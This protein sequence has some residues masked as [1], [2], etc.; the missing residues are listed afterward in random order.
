MIRA[1]RKRAKG[2]WN[3][4]KEA[5]NREERRYEGREIQEQLEENT[6]KIRAVSKKKI[7]L[8][9]DISYLLGNLRWIY[10]MCKGDLEALNK[11]HKYDWIQ[12]HNQKYYQ[13]GKK[14]LVEAIEL[15]K[16]ELPNKLKRQVRE[17]L[18]LF[19]IET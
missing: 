11:K 8:N 14:Q 13:Q 9:K 10:K 4:D 19:G 18:A 12:A 1:Y 7:K 3:N 17:V 16:Q 2:G 5:S 6:E 15:S